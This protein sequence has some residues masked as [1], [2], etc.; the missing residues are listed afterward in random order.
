MEFKKFFILLLTL[1]L[2]IISIFT[3]SVYCM[4]QENP[5]DKLYKGVEEN[6]VKA[7]KEAIGSGIDLN[8][9]KG[10]CWKCV[11]HCL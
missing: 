6:D 7:V 9:K 3:N 5:L 11:S 4:Q 10:V 1:P 8:K 2:L